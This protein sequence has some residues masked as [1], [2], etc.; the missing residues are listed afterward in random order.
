MFVARWI[1]DI[2]FGKSNDFVT[3]INQW[4]DEVGEKVGLSRDGLRVANGSIGAKESRF[5]FDYTIESMEKLQGMWDEM[6]KLEA[7]AKFG[8]DLEP[9]VV[10]GSSHWEVFRIIEL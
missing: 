4:Y 5:E 2:R 8:S 7:H 9:L 3:R 6:S 10:P 1:V